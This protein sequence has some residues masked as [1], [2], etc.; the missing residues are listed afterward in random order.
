MN[1]EEELLFYMKCWRELQS[2]LADV[3]RDDAE[4]YPYAEDILKLM[5]SIERKHEG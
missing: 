4:G 3:V 1:R 2:F 5:R